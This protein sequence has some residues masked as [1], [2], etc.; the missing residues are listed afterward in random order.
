[1]AH[2]SCTHIMTH[3]LRFK[4]FLSILALFWLATVAVHGQA[5]NPDMA[6]QVHELANR[7]DYDSLVKLIDAQEALWQK[8]ASMAYFR[9][10]FTIADVLTGERNAQSYWLGRK[11]LWEMLLKT[12]PPIEYGAA[13]QFYVWKLN[14]F[15][16]EAE[17]ITPYVVGLSDDDFALI[18]RDT[19]L[20]LVEYARQLQETIIPGYRDKYSAPMNDSVGKQ[21]FKQNAVDNEVQQGALFARS[22]LATRHINY[23]TVAY[24][25]RPANPQEL[26]QLLDI[27]NVQGADRDRL[28]HA[29]TDVE[30]ERHNWGK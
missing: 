8:A 27:L 9:D 15:F 24:S 2:N 16:L 10:M 21:R 17:D 12:R 23:L 11:V 4:A 7:G 20:M 3:K 18:R 30:F 29:T 1:M 22:D 13:Q 26:K 5:S 28:I 6:K 25:H 14:L 19:F